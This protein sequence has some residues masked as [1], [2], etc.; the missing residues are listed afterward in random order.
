MS[1][2]RTLGVALVAL[3]LLLHLALALGLLRALPPGIRLGLAFACLVLLPGYAW[4]RL[5]ALPPGGWWL[6][7]SWALGMGVMWNA[8]LVLATR[9]LGLP[10]TVLST[11]AAA[12]NA[13]L[14]AAALVLARGPVPAAGSALG[15][16]S[17]WA[18][19][20]AAGLSALFVLRVGPI[21]TYVSDAPDHIGTV[22][23]MLGSGDAFPKDAFFRDAG[24]GGADPRKGLWHPQIALL[25]RSADLDPLEA[26][27]GL[28][29]LIAP[30]TVLG[31][32]ALGLLISGSPGAAVAAWALLLVY[33]GSTAANPLR[34]MGYSSRLV[35][36]LALAAVVAVLADLIAPK[37][38]RRVAAMALAVGAIATHVFG[39]VILLLSLGA[40]G[41]GL[42]LRDRAWLADERRLLGTA[43]A[44]AAA[45]APYLLWRSLGSFAPGNIIHSEPQ[46]LMS[47]AAGLAVVSPGVLWDVMGWGWVLFPLAWWPLWRDGRGNAAV[48]HLLT[49]SVAVAAIAFNPLAV[50]ILQPRIGYLLMRLV[51]LLPLPGLVAWVVPGLAFGAARAL[52]PRRRVRALLALAVVLGLL[53]PGLRDSAQVMA[54]PALVTGP[55]RR[56]SPLRWRDALEWMD[57]H[58]PPGRVVLSDPV[59]SYSV[60]MMTRH[61]VVTMLDQHG[62][63]ND[64]R[65]LDRILDARDA[66]DPYGAWDRLRAVVERYGVDVI[67][68]NDR[69]AEVPRLDYWT[70]R[71]EWYAAARAR[72]D[73]HPEAFERVFDRDGLVIYVVRAAALAALT[74]SPPAR[75]FV[76]PFQSGAFPVARRQ[77]DG[78][79]ALHLVTFS[80]RVAAPGDTVRAVAEWRALEAMRPGSYFVTVRFDR[81]L[82]GGFEPPAAIGKPARKLLER[83]RGE[84]YRFSSS[85][86]P[87][88]G[89]YG[90]DQWRS[91]E[92]VR[93]SFELVVPRD[94]A[95][96]EYRA[97]VRMNLQPH[98]HNLRLS[99]YFVD[100]DLYAGLPSG[101]LLVRREGEKVNRVRN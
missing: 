96:G 39:A 46:G 21:E 40:L 101:S 93:D 8:L 49:S 69:F 67:A 1:R 6:S 82:P 41:L 48:L 20:A 86:L 92:V 81:D 99:D 53:W 98:Y 55:E 33:G 100:D 76:I 37:R 94:V 59:T 70:P 34:Q 87:A 11:W 80:S 2:A 85:H 25:C 60:P 65:A 45:A 73:R 84:R 61:Y 29:P 72:L 51:G 14:W 54:D 47:L 42:L 43:L 56:L 9:I 74:E 64:P 4:V 15:R 91:D 3:G 27:N 71:P 5:T 52:D 66:L 16:V 23:R 17:R 57:A 79:P 95:E 28:P 68:L 77:S 44:I 38:A 30:L 90:V 97:G 78:M 12:A 83:V 88:G 58:L 24:P 32:A 7:P 50:A 63:P 62:S 10:F 22:R 36:P 13:L 18:I 31:A 89:A 75:P 35:D 19:L 26:W